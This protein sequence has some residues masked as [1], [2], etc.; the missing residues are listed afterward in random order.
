MS[1]LNHAQ[2]M[3]DMQKNKAGSGPDGMDPADSDDSADDEPP[4]LEDAEE[5]NEPASS[6]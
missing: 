4:A 1:V 2:M 3:A 6:S 5:T